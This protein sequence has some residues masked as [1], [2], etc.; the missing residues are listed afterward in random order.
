MLTWFFFPLCNEQID[1]RVM[2]DL[3]DIKLLCTHLFSQD[4]IGNLNNTKMN[5]F[6]LHFNYRTKSITAFKLKPLSIFV[7]QYRYGIVD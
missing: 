5:L 7:H 2:I 6:L 3:S 1:H 4:E